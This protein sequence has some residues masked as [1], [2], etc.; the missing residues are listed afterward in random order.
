MAIKMVNASMQRAKL[1]VHGSWLR[2]YER[3][4]WHDHSLSYN[5]TS[6]P[7]VFSVDNAF[8]FCNLFVNQSQRSNWLTWQ[9]Y[10]LSK[11]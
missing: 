7:L 2:S 11:L 6:V 4:C 3:N 10:L 5:V 8:R 9:W 1:V